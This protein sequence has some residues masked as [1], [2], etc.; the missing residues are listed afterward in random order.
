MQAVIDAHPGAV[1]TGSFNGRFTVHSGQEAAERL[2]ECTRGAGAPLPEAIVCANDQMA[3]G[4]VRT[5]SAH[6]IKIPRDV[7]I[8]GFDDIFPASLT[9]P[10]LTTVH[11]PMR[12]I[13]ERA[14]DRLLERIAD[15]SL[16]PRI[17][18]LPSELVLRSSCGCPPGTVT[19]RQVATITRKKGTSPAKLPCPASP[20]TPVTSRARSADPGTAASTASTASTAGLP[21]TD[22][23]ND[24]SNER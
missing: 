4:M 6:G 22:P 20:V 11:Q 15:P 16:R 8:V 10:P 7:A 3:I 1:L 19:R 14:C 9:D 12:K 24:D 5:L 18:L 17:E 21:A 2:L 23:G 13:G